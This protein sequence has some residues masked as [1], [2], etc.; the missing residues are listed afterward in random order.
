MHSLYFV[1]ILSTGHMSL[2]F[3]L[4]LSPVREYSYRGRTSVEL[5]TLGHRPSYRNRRSDGCTPD[6][7]SVRFTSDQRVVELFLQKNYD[8]NVNAPIFT[9]KKGNYTQESFI[10]ENVA[11]YQDLERGSA[12]M[13][14]CIPSTRKL[15]L[16]GTF[17]N[18]SEEMMIEPEISEVQQE[19][20]AKNLDNGQGPETKSKG[21]AYLQHDV[22]KKFS[23]SHHALYQRNSHRPIFSDFIVEAELHSKYHTNTGQN[24]RVKRANAAYQVELLMVADFSVYNLWLSRSSTG[25]EAK[26]LLRQFYAFIVN[27]IDLRYKSITGSGLSITI[28]FAGLYIAETLSDALWTESRKIPYG[29]TYQIN[30]S[31]ALDDFKTWVQISSK[32]IGHDHAMLFTAYDLIDQNGNNVA[33]VTFL[34]STCKSNSQSIVLD[35]FDATMA[36]VAAHELGHSLGAM[37]DESLDGTGNSCFRNLSYIMAATVTVSNLGTSGFQYNINLWKFSPCSIFYFNAYINTISRINCMTTLSPA[38]NSSALF[39]YDQKDPGQVYSADD[40]CLY[41]RGPG[42]YVCR[43]IYDGNYTNTCAA[44]YCKISGSISCSPSIAAERTSCGYRK[45]CVAGECVAAAE[46]PSVNGMLN[47]S[48]KEN[49]LCYNL[50]ACIIQLLSCDTF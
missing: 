8:V 18:G 33:G 17:Y 49:L 38:Y 43:D 10:S 39:P 14:E 35:H 30:A 20:D 36:T 31:A 1:L 19:F 3:S 9:N 23:I 29:T 46:A 21:K 44:L 24:A 26:E 41:I 27:G 28:L 15:E 6:H 34:N 48:G 12:I 45:W 42:S 37:H 13:V 7:L 32:L 47:K 50:A 11:V 16:F 2:I 40:Q 5:I 22:R 25:A 4:R